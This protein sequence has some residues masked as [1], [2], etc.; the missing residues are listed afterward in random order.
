MNEN[1]TVKA[2]AALAQE[3]RLAVFRLLVLRG[4]D[5]Y[6]AGEISE[7]LAIPGPTLS[8]HLKEL[9]AAGLVAARKDGRFIYYSPNFERMRTLV[10]YLTDNCCSLAAICAP[11]CASP[12]AVR[13]KKKSA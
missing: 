4:P 13:R 11:E 8:F 12:V 1:D 7:Q 5:G 2:L 6:P 10:G 3:S 9:A